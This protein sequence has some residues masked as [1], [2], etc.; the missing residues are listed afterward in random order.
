M[1]GTGYSNRPSAVPSCLSDNAIAADS[2]V[3]SVTL[4][5][6]MPLRRKGR[7]SCYL[8]DDNE[9][10]SKKSTSILNKEQTKVPLLKQATSSL[11]SRRSRDR[12]T[13]RDDNRADDDPVGILRV[14]RHQSVSRPAGTISEEL[15][16]RNL[17]ECDVQ[18]ALN[19]ADEDDESSEDEDDYR[20][21]DKPG[22]AVN[23]SS[24]AIDKCNGRFV[25]NGGNLLFDAVSGGSHDAPIS[26]L[27]EVR[28]RVEREWEVGKDDSAYRE[29]ETVV[30][31]RAP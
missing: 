6:L 18:I 28:T 7:E 12:S 24:S 25:R 1:V 27:S 4:F 29:E 15:A 26:L 17:K 16:K 11:T 5:K 19:L 21:S 31:R 3:W 14:R 30:E 8:L 23:V 13:D 22:A 10:D 2:S 20:N 9:A